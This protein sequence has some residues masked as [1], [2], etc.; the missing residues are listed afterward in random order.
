MDLIKSEI[1]CK[2][3]ARAYFWKSDK[4]AE[5]SNFYDYQLPKAEYH[6]VIENS[7]EKDFKQLIN[8]NVRGLSVGSSGNV[9]LNDVLELI[10]HIEILY[11]QCESIS[12][13]EALF[14]FEKL[15]SFS[16]TS[17]KN[18]EVV[19]QLPLQLKVFSCT[20]KDKFQFADFPNSL[21]YLFI[22]KA[23]RLDVKSLINVSA[24]LLR[25]EFIDSVLHNSM[26]EII[27]LKS[28]RYLSLHNCSELNTMSIEGINTSLQYMYLSKVKLSDIE[29]ICKF[30]GL[31]V[32]ILE[33]CGNIDSLNALGGIKTLRGLWLSG[34]TKSNDGNLNWL[35]KLNK[36]ENLF[37]RDYSHYNYK[38]IF[39][40]SWKKFGSNQM[41]KLFEH[42]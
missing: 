17:N 32:L 36:L 24:N 33:N 22:E 12:Q 7:I 16:L 10:P 2:N 1:N 38:S 39:Q 6:L 13:V 4:V 20:W 14:Q 29:W 9:N 5:N 27:N 26:N 42:K 11:I 25:L 21:E 35:N 18:Q 34:N 30:V 37:I 15:I 8:S 41:S 19:F 23:K 3:G 31:E 40:W 28:L